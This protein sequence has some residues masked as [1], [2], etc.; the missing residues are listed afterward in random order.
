MYMNKLF[1]VVVFLICCCNSAF[2]VDAVTVPPI[3]GIENLSSWREGVKNADDMKKPLTIA[4]FGDSN[5]EAPIYTVAMRE[6]LQSCYGDHGTGYYTFNKNRAAIPRGPEVQYDGKW[7]NYDTSPGRDTPPPAPY[8]AMD[9]FWS[10]TEDAVASINVQFPQ[11]PGNANHRVR[12]HYQV[13]PGLGTFSIV[14]GNW[15]RIKINCAADKPTYAVTES[16]IAEQFKIT[17]ITGKVILFGCDS[18]RV[19]ILRGENAMPG[20]ALVYALGNGWGMS[21]HL[22]PTDE[23]AFK[24]FFETTKP[25]LVT[26]LFGTNDMHNDGRVATYKYN[27]TAIIDK[28]QKA[29]PGTGILV[30]SCPEAGQT[31]D[32]LAEEFANAIKEIAANKKCAFW[33]WRLL[34]GGHSRPAE[35]MGWMGDGLHYGPIGGSVF[36]HLLLKQLGFDVNDIKHWTSLIREKEQA[37]RSEIKIPRLKQLKIDEVANALKDEKAYTCW[38][39]D[40]K[41]ADVKFAVAGDSLAVSARIYDGRCVADQPVWAGSNI[42]VYV[43]KVGSWAGDENEKFRG[44]HGIIRQMVIQATGAGGGVKTSGHESG[45]DNAAPEFPTQVKL[46]QP[47][48]YELSALV[49]LSWLLIDEKTDS[50]YLE[51]AVVVA[52]GVGA[53]A[54]FCRLFL[55]PNQPDGGAFRDNTKAAIVTVK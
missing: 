23:Q 52:P 50:F 55:P 22:S 44:Y 28:I 46:M 38:N 53:P 49:P 19:K 24:K 16:F 34:M 3:I 11:I 2:S 33:D 15:E 12:V 48:G 51:S 1:I 21:Q 9:G 42:D 54:T 25:D 35:Q 18:D 27:M 36:A 20:G 47:Y 10:S 45:K 40:Q 14:T 37:G 30:I 39:L 6:I 26:I 8:Y 43:S 41:A 17:K 5:T 7:T 32:G 29:S 31:K 4:C 13:G